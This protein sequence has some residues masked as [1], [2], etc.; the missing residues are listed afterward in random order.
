MAARSDHI[1]SQ[2]DDIRRFRA[3]RDNDKMF[4]NQHQF[5]ERLRAHLLKVFRMKLSKNQ[6][7]NLVELIA[8]RV[9]GVTSDDAFNERLMKGVTTGGLAL[10]ET[11]ADEVTRY[12]E[13]LIAQGIDV[14][15]KA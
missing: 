11:E 6:D 15:Y 4:F 8:D 10:S 5:A 9:T 14:S 1:I 7:I 2:A 12:F 13:K 3:R